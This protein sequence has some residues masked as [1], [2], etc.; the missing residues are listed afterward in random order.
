ME[1]QE[2]RAP[3]L[4]FTPEN[5]AFLMSDITRWHILDAL[6][7]REAIAT[8]DLAKV[9]G[10]PTSRVAKHLHIL[11]DF[12][13]V[14]QRFGRTFSLRPGFRVPGERAIDFGCLLIRLDRLKRP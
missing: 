5:A 12:K 13:V 3:K 2:K 11:R 4:E 1:S 10:A 6:L 8:I 9:V 14:E 7:D